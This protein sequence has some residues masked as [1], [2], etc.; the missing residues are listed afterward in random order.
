MRIAIPNSD[1]AIK[2]TVLWYKKF[3]T[4]ENIEIFTLQQIKEFQEKAKL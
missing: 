2:N 4:G 3:Y 1:E